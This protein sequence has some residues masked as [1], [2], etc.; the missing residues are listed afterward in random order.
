MMEQSAFYRHYAQVAPRPQDWADHVGRTAEM[1][2]IDFDWTDEVA[3]IEAPTMLV[4]ADSD[5]VMPDHVAELFR[6][7][8]GG[9]RDAGWDGSAQPVARLAVLPGRTH[10]DMIE[11]PGLVRPCSRSSTRARRGAQRADHEVP[12][13]RRVELER[14]ARVGLAAEPAVEVDDGHPARPAALG[15]DR[16]ERVGERHHVGVDQQRDRAGVV[17]RRGE[18]AEDALVAGAEELHPALDGA[19]GRAGQR[20]H[21]RE[22]LARGRRLVGQVE[23]DHR[24]RQ[25][26][27]EHHRGGLGVDPDVELGR[28]RGVAARGR[29]AH[30]DDLAD[31]RVQV[32][33]RLQQRGDV[34]E[35]AGRHERDA[36]RR[37]PRA[38]R[39]SARARCA[40]P[41]APR[42]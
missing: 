35:R 25:A 16:H 1:L 24:Q 42:R 29:A 22:H 41:A 37:S 9:L 11:A 14:D 4:F 27:L 12:E 13:A 28:R 39:P 17:D 36:A 34:R 7:R 32:R 33:A 2:K 21:A 26:A 40:R 30:H 20:L 6:L 8:G 15:L 5:S 18:A 19:G 23:P 10:Y 31:P 3:A 38:W